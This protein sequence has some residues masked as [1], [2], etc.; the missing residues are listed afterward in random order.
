MYDRVFRPE[1]SV[2]NGHSGNV[3]CHINM[4]PVQP[5]QRK[6]RL[7]HYD[8]EKMVILQ[9]ECDKLEGQSVLVKP[10]EVGVTAEYMNMSFLVSKPQVPESFRLVTAFREI[11]EYSKP[12]PS[13]MPSVEDTL[14]AIGKWK[15]II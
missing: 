13:V 10:E 14:R 11:G 5:P 4:G 2:Y 3:Q 12:Q 6:A 1:I 8:H 15:Y 9:N 7:P